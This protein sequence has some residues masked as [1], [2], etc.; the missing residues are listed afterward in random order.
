VFALNN[1]GSFDID[2]YIDDIHAMPANP[3]FALVGNKLDL[4]DVEAL[5]LSSVKTIAEAHDVPLYLTSAKENI[6]IQDMFVDIIKKT[7][8]FT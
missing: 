3:S 4:V 2:E 7:L 5:D 8:Q 1:P 6:M